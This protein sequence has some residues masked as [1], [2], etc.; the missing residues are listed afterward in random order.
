MKFKGE[1]R[2]QKEKTYIERLEQY[3][4]A[5]SFSNVDKINNFTKYIPR[6]A[7]TKFLCKNELFKKVLCINGSIME[8]GVLFGGGLMTWAQLSAI[9]EPVN[10][11][12][13]IVG[14]DTF[15]GF[16]STAEQDET[17]TSPE[18]YK[19]GLA[20]D[21]H[22]DLKTSIELFDQN[23]P[24]GHIPKVEL[25]KGDARQTI[26]AYIKR[27][28]FLIV[29]LLYLDF[30]LYEP[31][32]TALENFLPRMPKGAII[33]FDELNSPSWPGETAAVF[34]KVG[35]PKLKIERFYFESYISY[36]ILE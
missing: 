5:S 30:D 29:S 2:T 3:I 23:R 8:C 11:T 19:G 28:P 10:Y 21:S 31:T 18:C 27:N 24:I 12:R 1:S 20:V 25:V 17:A 36:A 26:P 14:F 9:Y 7:L 13:K 34:E 15:E 6:Q 22:G 32:V 33:G 4:A 35:I 16:P